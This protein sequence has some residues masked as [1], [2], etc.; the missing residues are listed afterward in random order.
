MIRRLTTLGSAASLML[1]VATVVLW[2]RSYWV[3]EAVWYTASAA[4]PGT[5]E[6]REWIANQ[7]AGGILA[8]YSVRVVRGPPDLVGGLPPHSDRVGWSYNRW[9]A[10]G[11]GY[12]TYSY[13]QPG[14]T[15][16]RWASWGR[17][18]VAFFVPDGRWIDN[19][20]GVVVVPHAALVAA[21]VLLG[22]PAIVATRRASVQRRRRRDGRC[23]RCGFDLRATP[24]RCPECGAVPAGATPSVWQQH[25]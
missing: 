24:D 23:L 10:A 9:D 14:G 13:R 12:P 19:R 5:H 3:G 18:D 6:R 21:F 20:E 15:L 22:L 7:S 1:C 25:S 4:G 11:P 16:S 2:A 17:N 8:C